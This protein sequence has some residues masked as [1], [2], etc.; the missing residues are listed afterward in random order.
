LVR[1]TGRL[2]DLLD[3]AVYVYTADQAVRRVGDVDGGEIGAGWRR[4]FR[5]RIPVRLPEL[6]NSAPV[7]G[8]LVST[9]SFQSEDT[10]EFEFELLE[11][12]TSLDDFINFNETPYDGVVEEVVMFSGGLDSLAGAVTEAVTRRRRILL[13]NHRSNEKL[14]PR[15]RELLRGLA[16]HAG[17]YA[18]LH[19]PVR[20]NKAKRLGR[21]HTQRTRSFLFAAFGTTFAHMIGLRRLRFYENGVVSLNLPP[22]AQVVGARASR[23]THPR[24]L[25]GFGRLFTALLGREFRVEN[26]FLWE[27]KTDVVKR[28][29]DAECSDL[30]G[31]ST[32][33]GHTWERTARH[34]HCGVCSQCIDRRFAILA[35]GQE[36]HDPADAYAV[37]LLVGP[38]RPGESKTMLAAYLELANRVERMGEGE[39][40]TQF[41]ELPRALPHLGLPAT[42]GVARVFDL[43]RRHA[44]QVNRAL[45]QA[46]VANAG[47]IRRHEL[48]RNCLLRLVMDDG[49]S[50]TNEADPTECAPP[51]P[52][53]NYFVRRKRFWAIRYGAGEENIYPRDRGFD[54]L[55]LLLA[56]PGRRFT[57]SELAACVAGVGTVSTLRAASAAEE[58]AGGVGVT[59]P[60]RGD[61]ALDVETRDAIEARLAEVRA[62]RATLDSSDSPACVDEADALEV[63]ER[64]LTERLRRDRG[65]GGRSRKLGDLA[66]RVRKRVC[67][68]IRRALDLIDD[69]DKPLAEHLQK[70]T[71]TTGYTIVYQPRSDMLWSVA[72]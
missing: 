43:Y 4:T 69:D 66:E 26:P 23:T 25:D 54:Y 67:V 29:A 62:R 19:F 71:L 11:K 18:P 34:T 20:L 61:D 72:D 9:L 24:V 68:A 52:A 15:H 8:A 60:T 40:R 36:A 56:H 30:I 10:Y 5:F 38:R 22:S 7:C 21:E 63:E 44:R 14:S 39:F 58:T 12:D 32:S 47:A 33:C 1:D 2:R 27:T 28:I 37:D 35:A 65:L 55:R 6:W 59:R 31:L 53:G 41:G 49:P 45:E 13:L 3:I 50:E 46:I 48:S 17:E 51:T 16:R 42:A 64:Q 57:V 70:P